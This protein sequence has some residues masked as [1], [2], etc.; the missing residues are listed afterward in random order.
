M[1]RPPLVSLL[2]QASLLPK[3]VWSTHPPFS[4]FYSWIICPPRKTFRPK[5]T[6]RSQLGRVPWVEC[7]LCL[8]VDLVIRDI[9][10]RHLSMTPGTDCWA[11]NTSSDPRYRNAFGRST[12][13]FCGRLHTMPSCTIVLLSEK[14]S[15][16]ERSGQTSDTDYEYSQ[17]DN[18]KMK[19]QFFIS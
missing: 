12:N 7:V 19:L 15:R 10:T 8:K 9:R 5:W 14:V 4:A 11:D 17:N 18:D 13:R 1:W 3:W 2:D 16:R 6:V